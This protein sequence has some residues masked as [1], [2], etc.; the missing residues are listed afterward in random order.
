LIFPRYASSAAA[1][2]GSQRALTE[3]LGVYGTGVTFDEMRFLFNYQAVR[4]VNTFNLMS[5]PYGRFSFLRAGEGPLFCEESSICTAVLPKFN[6]YLERLSYISSLGKNASDTALYMPVCD[7]WAQKDTPY[8]TQQFESIGKQ[9][10]FDRITFDVIDDD[11]LRDACPDALA[12]G[13]IAL[14]IASYRTVV[15]PPTEYMPDA[16]IE[17]LER[18]ITAGG[19][20]YVVKGKCTPTISGACYVDT[21]QNV[22]TAPL[23]VSADAAKLTLG[24][25]KAQNADIFLLHNE[26]LQNANICVDLTD[27]NA[28]NVYILSLED[29]KVIRPDLQ[30]GILRHSLFCGELLC[31]L[32]TDEALPYT[33]KAQYTNC[34]TIDGPF[35]FRK[36]NRLI[37]TDVGFETKLFDEPFTPIQL[38]DWTDTLGKAFSGSFALDAL[39]VLSSATNSASQGANS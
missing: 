15:I 5:L 30:E 27:R 24:Y 29:G 34:L 11:I 10:E 22:L 19:K 9:M 28:D 36:T 16:S 37:L 14:G 39:G 12:K 26:S 1:Q 17:A 13:E 38:G 4:G 35:D 32:I 25:R 8:F 6:S 23:R 7:Y 3:S 2:I 18:F 31:L 33:E 21:I 20:V